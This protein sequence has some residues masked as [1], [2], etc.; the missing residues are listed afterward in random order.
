MSATWDQE[1]EFAMG[2]CGYGKERVCFVFSPSI[3]RIPLHTVSAFDVPLRTR[4]QSWG[5]PNFCVGAA[6]TPEHGLLCLEYRR[7][8]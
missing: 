8:E 7:Q 2:V 5:Q 6:A 4:E 1:E 3:E